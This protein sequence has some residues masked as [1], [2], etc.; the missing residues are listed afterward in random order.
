MTKGVTLPDIK[1][2]EKLDTSNLQAFT[3]EEVM[4]LLSALPKTKYVYGAEVIEKGKVLD[5]KRFE[6]KRATALAHI[7]ANT[8][9]ESLGLS[10]SDD[11][12]AYALNDEKVVESE[13]SV[14]QAS[15]DYEMAKLQFGYAD[16]LFIA[17]RKVATIVEKQLDAQK[18]AERYSRAD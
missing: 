14:V 15:G 17:V 1:F 3:I 6:L 2:A 4:A 11:R 13:V 16:D 7:N 12:K 8:N 9:K 18:E 10:S 5:E